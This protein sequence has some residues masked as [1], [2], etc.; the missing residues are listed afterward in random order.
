MAS[1]LDSPPPSLLDLRSLSQEIE[2]MFRK[3]ETPTTVAQ[4]TW[5]KCTNASLDPLTVNALLASV[6]GDDIGVSTLHA[7]VTSSECRVL[8]GVDKPDINERV[9]IEFTQCITSAAAEAHMRGYLSSFEVSPSKV[10]WPA[11][12]GAYSLQTAQ[13]VFW[14][15]DTMFAKIFVNGPTGI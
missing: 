4:P 11:N 13:S 15:R 5:P 3:S 12:I 10:A 7:T 6:L 2:N 9:F 8:Y 1:M 14:I